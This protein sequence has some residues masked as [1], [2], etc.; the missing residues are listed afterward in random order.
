MSTF[1][2]WV[3]VYLG[4]LLVA[5]MCGV[6]W[7]WWIFELA[8]G[9]EKKTGVSSSVSFLVFVLGVLLAPWG[10]VAGSCLRRRWGLALRQ[11][12]SL[13]V[14]YG[15]EVG[16]LLTFWFWVEPLVVEDHLQ[17]PFPDSEAKA[18]AAGVSLAAP[19]DRN[20]W[21]QWGE[22]PPEPPEIG[23][24]RR[25]ETEVLLWNGMQGGMFNAWI[26]ANPGEPGELCL[27]VFENASQQ[28]V[29]EDSKIERRNIS[30]ATRHV[31]RFSDDAEEVFFSRVEFTVY[32]EGGWEH[33]FAGRVELWFRPANGMEERRLWQRVFRLNGWER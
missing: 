23:F 30:G 18:A 15:A 32:G 28:A 5:G 2:F 17:H 31:A 21:G 33:F 10:I 12:I 1:S 11:S 8:Y 26:W 6:P 29:S 24:A 14:V 25:A 27:R 7:V 22:K 9:L 4:V 3:A 19:L 20:D 16:V 13:L